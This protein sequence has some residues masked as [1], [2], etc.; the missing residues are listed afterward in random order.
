MAK[1]YSISKDHVRFLR[2]DLIGADLYGHVCM[3]PQK[4]LERLGI[5]YIKAIPESIGDCWMILTT[6]Q[7]ELPD[8]ID[9]MEIEPG[10]EYWYDFGFSIK[11]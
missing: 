4:D 10:N 11:E 2:Y 8:Y 5:D 6:Y 3:H 7:G 9:D 1:Q